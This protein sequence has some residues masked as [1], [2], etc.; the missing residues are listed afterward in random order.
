LTNKIFN[1]IL[2]LKH[3]NISGLTDYELEMRNH[4]IKILEKYNPKTL[5][6]IYNIKDD[7]GFALV[8]NNIEKYIFE[9]KNK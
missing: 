1:L 2:E 6:D 8:C 7:N 3:I 5:N 4:H 9:I